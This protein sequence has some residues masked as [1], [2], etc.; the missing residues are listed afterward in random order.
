MSD[1]VS[2]FDLIISGVGGQG[3]ILASDI[4][5]KTAVIS[6]YHVRAAET[7]G[8]AQRGGSVVN[9]VR[10]GCDYGSLISI[11]GA[12][13]MIALEPSESVRYLKYLAPG[14]KIIINTEPVYPVSVLSGKSSYPAISDILNILEKDHEVIAFNATKLAV[15]A[16]NQQA[17]N[18]VMVGALSRYLPFDEKVL[19]ESVK[20]IVPPKTLDV[21]KKAFMLGNKIMES[22]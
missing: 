3:T 16:G 20:S 7:H 11:N 14:S 5:G 8:M 10:I 17:M 19:F 15:E 2:K 1:K 4:I 6:G 21:N 12:D 9:H 18:V 13:F 22:H